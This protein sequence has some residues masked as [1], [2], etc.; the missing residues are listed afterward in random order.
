[1]TRVSVLRAVTS[2]IAVISGL[3]A[4]VFL[5]GPAGAEPGDNPCDLA[6]NFYCK[7]VPIAPEL[8]NDI[9]LTQQQPPAD[10]NAPL[11]ESLP[12]LDPCA[13]GCI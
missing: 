4:A 13:A 8:E 10:P 6:I 5:A 12:P 11:P 9:D 2:V 1:V 7:F 3:I